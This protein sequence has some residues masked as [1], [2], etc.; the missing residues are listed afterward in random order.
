MPDRSPG[1]TPDSYIYC[2]KCGA[3]HMVSRDEIDP[4]TTYQEVAPQ[5]L[6]VETSTAG[7]T[8]NTYNDLTIIY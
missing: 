8:V 1:G 2:P 6:W 4:W 7:T 5:P 3:K